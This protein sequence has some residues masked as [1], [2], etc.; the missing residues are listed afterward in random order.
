MQ[1]RYYARQGMTAWD[2]G[3]IPS[4]MSSNAFNALAYAR[5]IDG[6]IRDCRGGGS[7][8]TQDGPPVTIVELGAGPGRFAY[9]TIKSLVEL[10]TDG[11]TD[12]VR[13]HYMMTD[14]TE[15]NIEAWK[16][17]GVFQEF[18]DQGVLSFSLFDADRPETLEALLSN[19]PNGGA[20]GAT[21]VIAN[22]V[23]DT[24]RQDAFRID[25]GVLLECRAAAVSEDE[26]DPDD[27]DILKHISLQREFP[28]VESPYYEDEALDKVLADYSRILDDTSFLIPIGFIRCLQ[29]FEKMSSDAL[30]FLLG[31]KGRLTVS[32]LMG[33]SDSNLVLHDGCFSFS[34]N[35][36]ALERYVT[37]RGATAMFSDDLD[38]GFIVSAFIEGREGGGFPET[39]RAFDQAI[40]RFSPRDFHNLIKRTHEAAEHLTLD[41]I[42]ILIKL[43]NYETRIL[44]TF[45]QQIIEAIDGASER[46]RR[47]TSLMLERV[48]GNHFPLGISRDVPYR[49]G[50]IHESLENPEEAIRFY[51]HSLEEWGDHPKTLYRI[52]RCHEKLGDGEAALSF[53]G[54]SLL[55]RPD[56]KDSLKLTRRLAP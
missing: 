53:A 54:R 26:R 25:N 46:L 55:M 22:Y 33:S 20:R 10:T 19:E 28:C 3:A 42:L 35:F 1:K 15:Q 14:F 38:R 11:A 12:G 44:L 51:R 37:H 52:A 31:D 21:V 9:L 27:G 23:V 30:L 41:A 45:R 2:S 36:N 56:D 17:C 40:G 8:R 13:F 6:F 24:L 48:W 16:S 29:A 34:A 50:V 4:H 47:E 18:L 32:D 39:R 5:V 49:I 7:G 43:S